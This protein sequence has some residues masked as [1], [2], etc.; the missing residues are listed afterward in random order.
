[1]MAAMSDRRMM[2]GPGNGFRAWF[3]FCALAAFAL[4]GVLVWAVIRLVTHYAG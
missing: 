3:A 4:T 2:P 1:M